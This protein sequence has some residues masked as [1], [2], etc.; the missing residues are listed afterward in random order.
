VRL[1]IML[2]L[3]LDIAIATGQTGAGEEELNV[4]VM[5]GICLGIV[6]LSRGLATALV[7]GSTFVGDIWG[8]HYLLKQLFFP[9]RMNAVVVD[10]VVFAFFVFFYSLHY[11]AYD[12]GRCVVNHC[13]ILV[14][15]RWGLL[16]DLCSQLCLL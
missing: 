11:T 6:W 3:V 15:E 12:V 13:P 5:I 4:S 9:N 1:Q 10:W 8:G 2:I 7:I 16:R 14:F